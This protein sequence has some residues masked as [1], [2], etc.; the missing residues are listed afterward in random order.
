[1]EIDA[2]KLV[3][4]KQNK[5]IV[6]HLR[7]NGIDGREIFKMLCDVH[8]L[9]WIFPVKLSQVEKEKRTAA[10][11][12]K[13]F[14][15]GLISNKAIAEEEKEYLRKVQARLEKDYPLFEKQSGKP[16]I[17][18]VSANLGVG[19]AY[20]VGSGIPW[21]TWTRETKQIRKPTK[22][23]AKTENQMWGMQIVEVY[24]Y[25]EEFNS[26]KQSSGK[27]FLQK[28]IFGLIAELFNVLFNL[29]FTG[30]KIRTLYTNAFHNK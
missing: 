19:P 24:D 29:K 18:V 5:L 3:K 15:S 25:I 21:E 12:A 16:V 8:E 10:S 2:L 9:S 4:L 6:K 26:Y 20:D 7:G 22:E 11:I 23:T 30:V 28:D 13:R 1:M 27:P 17:K 14:I